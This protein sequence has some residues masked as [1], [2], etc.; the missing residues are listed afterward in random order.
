MTD[1]LFKKNKFDCVCK[2]LQA[3]LHSF[4]DNLEGRV[5]IIGLTIYLSLYF[6][7]KNLFGHDKNNF[8]FLVTRFSV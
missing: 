7:I 4:L 3:K 5:L 8:N 2:F 1:K 6:L